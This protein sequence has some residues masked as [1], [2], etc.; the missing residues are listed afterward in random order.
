MYVKIIIASYDTGKFYDHVPGYDIDAQRLMVMRLLGDD[1]MTAILPT[2]AELLVVDKQ[3]L[4]FLQRLAAVS[5]VLW[6]V[7]C[8]C[9]FV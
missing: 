5:E 3:V 2:L 4:Y 6:A 8:R 7:T 9:F 1:S